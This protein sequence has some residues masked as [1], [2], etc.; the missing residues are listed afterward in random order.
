M[1]DDKLMSSGLALWASRNTQ[2]IH[3]QGNAGKKHG[4]TVCDKP[5]WRVSDGSLNP[6]LCSSCI[7]EA[8]ELFIR[9]KTS[10]L[11]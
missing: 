7:Q 4:C 8:E 6:N 2:K 9:V 1:N 3:T 11:T 10:I 5:I